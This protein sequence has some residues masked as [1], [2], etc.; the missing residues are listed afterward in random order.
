MPYNNAENLL[1]ASLL[2][3][4]Q[5][6]IQGEQIYIPRPDDTRL[7]WGMKNGT[8]RMLE[9]RNL[10]IREM[11]SKGFSVMDL[12]D[13]YNLSEDSIKKILYSRKKPRPEAERNTWRQADSFSA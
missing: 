13:H 12:A 10:E 5:K 6:Y 3:E 1:P 2:S 4:V 7:G 8:R 9:R 11:K